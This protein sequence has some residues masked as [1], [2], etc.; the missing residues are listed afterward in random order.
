MKPYTQLAVLLFL[1]AACAPGDKP[2]PT[3]PDFRSASAP[4][5]T[6]ISVTDL[7]T[8]GGHN[9]NAFGLNTPGA[10]S[11]LLIVGSSQ[12]KAGTGHAAYWYVD[13]ASGARQAGSLPAPPGSAESGASAVNQSETIVGSSAV[14]AGGPYLPVRWA[15]GGWSPSFL[16]VNGGTWGGTSA[17]TNA[18]LIVGTVGA[19]SDAH[20]ALWEGEALTDLGTFGGNVSQTFA[21]N[22]AG[23]AVGES[24][25]FGSQDARAFV[26]TKPGPIVQLPDGG[27]TESFATAIND[28][29]VIAGFVWSAAEG[30]HA[31]RWLPPTTIGGPYTM[32]LLGLPKS[33]AFGINNAGEIVGQYQPGFNIHG[34]YWLN[35]TIKDL[36]PLAL[37]AS[38]RAINE[39]GDVIGSGYL[40][41]SYLHAVLWTHVR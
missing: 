32:Q 35:G 21:V 31:V 18:G 28:A 40:R 11:R 33:L 24:H 9:S 3:A 17:I 6:P 39:N 13:V 22:T 4:Q 14:T 8:L 7:G 1:G 36:P 30:E 29:G 38:A 20:A 12:D 23:V 2:G 25:Y 26:W 27:Y 41:N 10:G 15:P 5:T 19:P 37:N 16:N 34:F